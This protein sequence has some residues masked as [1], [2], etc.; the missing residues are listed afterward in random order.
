MK[1]AIWFAVVLPF[2]YPAIPQTVDDVRVE[3]RQVKAD[4]AKA[5]A[6]VDYLA[7]DA[8][9][10]RRSGTVEYRKAAEYVAARFREYGLRPGGEQGGYFQEVPIKNVREVAPPVRLAIT[11]PTQ[12]VYYP[13]YRRDF[14]PLGGTGA[15]IVR[16]RLTFAGYGVVSQAAGWN[17]YDGIDV[18][19][20]VVMVLVGTPPGVSDQERKTWT[21]ARKIAAARE[22]GVGVVGGWDGGGHRGLQV[23]GVALLGEGV[24]G[25]AAYSGRQCRTTP[26]S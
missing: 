5:K 16:G 25:G 1:R 18:S 23:S 10:G 15:G 20:R 13:G 22:R 14:Q 17:D 11:S 6:H 12:R 19:G 24:L 9:K 4:G 7:S 8:M 3:A 21:L 2:L 26:F